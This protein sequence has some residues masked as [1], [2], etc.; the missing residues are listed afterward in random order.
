[1]PYSHAVGDER[2]DYGSTTIDRNLKPFIQ[3]TV[4][5]LCLRHSDYPSQ[6][7]QRPAPKSVMHSFAA[8]YV[9]N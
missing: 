3:P 1:M 9:S 4:Q 6:S 7:Q 2:S 8:G 5:L